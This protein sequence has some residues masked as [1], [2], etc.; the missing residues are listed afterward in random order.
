MPDLKTNSFFWLPA[1]ALAAVALTSLI[2]ACAA[3]STEAPG[4]GPVA[5]AATSTQD[6]H[7]PR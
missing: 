7:T 3:L 1:S 4:P 6:A 5:T 2:V